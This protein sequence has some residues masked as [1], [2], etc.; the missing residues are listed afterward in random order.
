MSLLHK[1]GIISGLIPPALKLVRANMEMAVELHDNLLHYMGDSLAWIPSL[2]PSRNTEQ[3]G[4]D[5]WGITIIGRP[6][7]RIACNVFTSWANLF[8]LSPPVLKLTGFYQLGSND[9]SEGGAY[10]RLQFSRDETVTVLR[11]IASMCQRVA[12][13]DG[14][15]HVLH[16]GI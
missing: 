8:S 6:G 9:T 7:A 4:L 15:E 10:E 3:T 13:G 14:S 12:D 11:A 5:Y 16:L 2:N 1:F